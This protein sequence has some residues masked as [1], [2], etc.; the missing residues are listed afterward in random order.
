MVK[1]YEPLIQLHRCFGGAQ[2][3]IWIVKKEKTKCGEN[4]IVTSTY[5]I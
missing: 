3:D 5:V 1:I 2:F 4:Y